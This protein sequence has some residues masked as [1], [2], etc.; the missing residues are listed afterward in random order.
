[1]PT[2][3]RGIEALLLVFRG[4][5]L[6]AHEFRAVMAPCSRSYLLSAKLS[7]TC[8]PPPRRHCRL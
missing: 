7:G 2:R 3:H 8:S 5:R 1:M 6:H 4:R